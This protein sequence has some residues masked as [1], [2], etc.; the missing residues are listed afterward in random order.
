MKMF[1]LD[2]KTAK[3]RKAATFVHGE[4]KHGELSVENGDDATD[5][6]YPTDDQEGSIGNLPQDIIPLNEAINSAKD[7]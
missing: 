3:P 5:H 6:D 2:K 1:G 4:G 7:S